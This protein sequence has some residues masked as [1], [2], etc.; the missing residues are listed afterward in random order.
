MVGLLGVYVP[1]SPLERQRGLIGYVFLED[2]IKWDNQWCQR[3][4][5]EIIHNVEEKA[6]TFINKKLFFAWPQKK[7]EWLDVEF[8][9]CTAKKTC[10]LGILEG[11][12]HFI[13]LTS[14][15]FQ[16]TRKEICSLKCKT[17]IYKSVYPE[18]TLLNCISSLINNSLSTEMQG[19]IY[20]FSPPWQ[21]LSFL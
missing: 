5:M 16:F 8:M 7:L 20:F 15:F 21:N 14:L 17:A 2:A 4:I 1:C 3:L 10:S 18:H 9:K 19:L 13:G 12:H 11:H 6:Q